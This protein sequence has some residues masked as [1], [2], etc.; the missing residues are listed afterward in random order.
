MSDDESDTPLDLQEPTSA[1]LAATFVLPSADAN[2][3]G[4]SQESNLCLHGNA[5]VH[6]SRVLPVDPGSEKALTFSK[7]EAERAVMRQEQRKFLAAKQT[8]LQG[9]VMSGHS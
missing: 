7:F 3:S 9:L 2:L 6:P 8:E 5:V 4:Q 1:R